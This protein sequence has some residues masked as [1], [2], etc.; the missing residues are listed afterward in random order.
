MMDVKWKKT[1][2]LACICPEC[3]IEHKEHVDGFAFN[4]FKNN[5]PMS[6]LCD[7]CFEK[8]RKTKKLTQ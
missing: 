1:H 3:K 6:S 8:H 7:I 2:S 5:Q 4:K